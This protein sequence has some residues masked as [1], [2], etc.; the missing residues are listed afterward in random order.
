MLRGKIQFKTNNTQ[1]LV[2]V[3]PLTHW[4]TRRN[5]LISLGTSASSIKVDWSIWVI[6]FDFLPYQRR[7]S[8]LQI[9][10][11]PLKQYHH[12]TWQLRARTTCLPLAVTPGMSYVIS[13]C[14]CFLLCKMRVKK[15][16]VYHQVV[17][18]MK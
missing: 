4:A 8:S 10:P 3:L 16:V 7:F 9:A 1:F 13:V 5:L 12:M 17:K 11:L 14:L 2:P 18:R 15:R 6:S